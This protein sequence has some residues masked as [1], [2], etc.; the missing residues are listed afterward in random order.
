M[1]EGGVEPPRP[2]GHWN[3]NPARLPIPPPAHWVCLRASHLFGATAWRHL[4]ISTSQT[5]DSHPFVSDR[6]PVNRRRDVARRGRRR[7]PAGVGSGGRVGEPSV[8]HAEMRRC[9]RLLRERPD[10]YSTGGWSGA[11]GIGRPAP[12]SAARP[13]RHGARDGRER[14]ARSPGSAPGGPRG[15]P[16]RTPRG[17][18]RP[19][20]SA[21]RSAQGNREGPLRSPGREAEALAEA[22]SPGGDGERGSAREAGAMG[23]GG[24]R[25]GD[26][27][28]GQKG[29]SSQTAPLAPADRPPLPPAPPPCS[30]GAGHCPGAAPTIHREGL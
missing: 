15:L 13:P 2:F 28:A 24:A 23:D 6:P 9:T 10:R 16:G 14:T 3:L 7:G 29:E 1:R 19:R 8:R 21:R 17:T 26:G 27:R 20:R 30:P 12:T 11:A 4:K 25:G 5:V 22:P 18:G